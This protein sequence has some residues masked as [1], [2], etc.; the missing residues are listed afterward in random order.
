[1]HTWGVGTGQNQLAQAMFGVYD[2]LLKLDPIS[3][4]VRA[5]VFRDLARLP[6]V[7]SIG[8]VVDPLGRTGYGIAQGGAPGSSE[9][10][11]VIAPGTGLLL[12]DEYVTVSS[13]HQAPL[14][15]SGALPG[16]ARC[17]KGVQTVKHMAR[18]GGGHVVCM[19]TAAQAKH[20][21]AGDGTVVNNGQV[22]VGTGPVL[23]LAPGQLQYYDAIVSAGWTNTS[24]PL[25]P[26][27]QQFSV[28][29]D[30]KG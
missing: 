30:G 26:R 22:L 21:P 28:A 5:A 13:A 10:V 11:L 1:V 6:G 23:Q 8:K 9:E 3:P 12:S 2:Q 29:K 27:A 14:P 4:A 25:P 20:L 7:R 15:S 24:P 19:M 17:P 16:L 18:Q